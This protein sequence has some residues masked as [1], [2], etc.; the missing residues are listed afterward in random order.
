MRVSIVGVSHT[1]FTVSNLVQSIAFYRDLIG[2][3]LVTTIERKMPWIAEMTGFTGAT[4]KLA[5]L[6][7]PGEMH[8]LELIEYEAPRGRR[9]TLSTNDV[10][11]THLGFVVT[12]IHAEYKRLVAAG[13]EFV[14]APVRVTE[15]PSQGAWAAYF[16]DPDGLAL[17]LQ[18]RAT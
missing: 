12:D 1:S 9:F 3:E 5:V 13:V 17:E 6:R 8:M 2:L 14:A 7:W 11:S 15:P 18:Q 10:G 16:R 4:L